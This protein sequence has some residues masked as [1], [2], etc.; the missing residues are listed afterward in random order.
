MTGSES[1]VHA[2]R[3]AFFRLA[4][5]A[6]R[7]APRSLLAPLRPRNRKKY[8]VPGLRPLTLRCTVLSVLLRARMPKPLAPRRRFLSRATRSPTL[9]A[10]SARVHSSADVLLTS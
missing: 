3:N 2:K 9:P 1:A 7:N 10:L 5:G 8:L 6:V 4:L